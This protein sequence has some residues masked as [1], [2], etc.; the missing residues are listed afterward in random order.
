MLT[1]APAGAVEEVE[2]EVQRLV[3][4][5]EP[6]RQPPLHP[7][8]EQRLGRARRPSPVRTGVPGQRRHEHL[9]LEPGGLHQRRLAD[10]GR[11]HAVGDEEHV[12]VEAGALVAGP[13]LRDDAVDAHRARPSGQGPLEGDDVVE[14][15]VRARARRP[16]RTRA[17]W[18]PRCRSPART[19]DRRGSAVDADHGPNLL[20]G[21]AASGAEPA[22]GARPPAGLS[23]GA[24][25]RTGCS[26]G[27]GRWSAR[28]G[29]S[30][31]R[32]RRARGRPARSRSAG[33]PPCRAGVAAG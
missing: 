5:G 17:A 31:P 23:E 6:G 4:A 25:R 29:G 28:A 32:R 3:V 15:E 8:E 13:D 7:V 9:G 21:C 10:L 33:R 26:A 19:G 11:Q 12:A 20:R 27:P 22:S 16:P 30:R 24:R 2:V 1:W 14:L 18:R